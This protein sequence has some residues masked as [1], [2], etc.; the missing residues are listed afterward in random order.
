ME[1][2]KLDNGV[3]L[4]LDKFNSPLFTV[5][6]GVSVGSLYEEEDERGVTHLLEHMLFHVPDLDVDAAVESI[7]GENNAYTSRDSITIVID[8]LAESA[9]QA[10]ELAY[11]IYTNSKFDPQRLEREKAVVLSE[12]RLSREDPS[13]RVGEL[14]LKALFG[15]SDWGAPVG[16]HPS[17]VAKLEVRDLTRHKEK[18]FVPENTV[19]SLSGGFGEEAVRKVEDLFK[20][21]EGPPPPR[22][23]PTK[24]RG[25]GSIVEEREV[26]GLYYAYAVEYAVDTTASTY[27]DLGAAAFHLGDGTKSILFHLLRSRGLSY[28]YYVDY[29]VVE[30]TAYLLVAV[31]SAVDLDAV[32][33]AVEEALRPK[34]APEYRK[35]YFKYLWSRRTPA[36]RALENLEFYI[37]RGDPTRLDVDMWKA[38]ENGTTKLEGRVINTAEAVIHA[39]RTLIKPA[40][41]T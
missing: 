26:D 29:D 41:A 2:K 17:T 3:V 15:D 38:V 22:K 6:V 31:E 14:A 9:L 11:R 34:T 24:S 19:L 35:R 25:P 16:G 28:S 5:A 1:V 33:R 8:A 7:G 21:I 32:K 23:R 18:W 36:Q 37:K 20:K 40:S 4:V 12:L 10:V 30:D 39:R 27:L 13:E